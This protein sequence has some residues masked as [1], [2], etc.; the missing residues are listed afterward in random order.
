MTERHGRVKDFMF[1]IKVIGMVGR[2][3]RMGRKELHVAAFG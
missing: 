2:V 1:M 3:E